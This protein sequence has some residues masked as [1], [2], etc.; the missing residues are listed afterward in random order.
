M[1]LPLSPMR[2]KRCSFGGEEGGVGDWPTVV[3]VGLALLPA[4]RALIGVNGGGVVEAVSLE[5]DVL[6]SFTADT[7]FPS[8][9]SC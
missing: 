6:A 2:G 8:F 4:P 5:L 7:G 3:S 9:T 1:S